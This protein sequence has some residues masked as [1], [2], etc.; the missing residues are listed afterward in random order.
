MGPLRTVIGYN[1]CLKSVP[2]QC[3]TSNIIHS[4]YP[5]IVNRFEVFADN[6]KYINNISVL[7]LRTINKP[8][9]EP[10]FLLPGVSRKTFCSHIR[11]NDNPEMLF[12]K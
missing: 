1:F 2:A 11:I 4:Q 10:V 6:I 7:S 8:V 9:K 5:D 12:D 3:K